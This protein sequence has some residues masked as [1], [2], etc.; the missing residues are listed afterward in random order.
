MSGG[1]THQVGSQRM[2]AQP[3]TSMVKLCNIILN[4]MVSLIEAVQLF[5]L[6]AL[7]IYWKAVIK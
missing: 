3:Y 2:T 1:A 4:T 5:M 6:P 7:I